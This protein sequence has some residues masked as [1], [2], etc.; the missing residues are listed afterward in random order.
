ADDLGLS[1]PKDLSLIGYDNT[2][3]AR[4]RHLSLTSVDNGNF[5]V[6]AQAGRYLIERLTNPGLEARLH[7][8]ATT[9]EVR[10]STA[11]PPPSSVGLPYRIS[12]RSSR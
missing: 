4:I 6:G 9:L 2:Y 10:S 8:V 11:A 3:L 1:V 7:L 5:P 12:R